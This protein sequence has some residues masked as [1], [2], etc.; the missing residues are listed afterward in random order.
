M[1]SNMMNIIYAA[2]RMRTGT[3]KTAFSCKDDYFKSFHVLNSCPEKNCPPPQKK[4]KYITKYH[5]A[6]QAACKDLPKVIFHP[7]SSSTKGYLPPNVVFHQRLSSTDG[8]LP[9]KVIFHRR[10][11]ST[12]G[13]LPQKVVFHQRSSCTEGCLP[14]KVVFHLRSSSNKGLLPSKGFF[15]QP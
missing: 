2:L 15:H 11:S 10:S 4:I 1:E 8:L 3:E 12:K 6:D 5:K 7:R 13:H 14:L 9:L